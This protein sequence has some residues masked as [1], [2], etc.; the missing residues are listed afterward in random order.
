MHRRG[1]LAGCAAL[2]ATG[3]GF[4]LRRA[5]EFAFR[6]VYVE[7]RPG[8]PLAAE[9]RRAIESTGK[10]TVVTETREITTAQV[11]LE[12]LTDQREKAVVGLS[13]SGQV[14]QF[15]LRIRFKFKVRTP[16]GKELI[17]PTELLQRRD[18][19]YSESAALSKEAEEGLLYREM[20]SD[21]VQQVLRRLAAVKGF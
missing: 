8:S 2:A 21:I 15:E 16:Q 6:R 3:C 4:E 9:L 12:A 10:V 20:Q 1:L 17:E 18:L 13:A 7:A 14:R 19:G 5:P 11:V